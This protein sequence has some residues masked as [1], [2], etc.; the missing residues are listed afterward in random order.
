MTE[1]T[2][3]GNANN[4][5]RGKIIC[6]GE[7]YQAGIQKYNPTFASFEYD[8]MIAFKP[9]VRNPAKLKEIIIN[10]NQKHRI[11]ESSPSKYTLGFWVFYT[12]AVSE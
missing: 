8:L 10:E 5:D 12:Q 2:Y 7:E 1:Q 9:R 11:I 3:L 4:P 6:E